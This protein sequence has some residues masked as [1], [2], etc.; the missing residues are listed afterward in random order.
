MAEILEMLEFK[1]H[2][3]SSACCIS[4]FV[5]VQTLKLFLSYSV[6]GLSYLIQII[7]IRYWILN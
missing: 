1:L 7:Q 2:F 5:L 6:C 3:P 4:V